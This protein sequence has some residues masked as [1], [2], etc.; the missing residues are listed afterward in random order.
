[1]ITVVGISGNST[2][3]ARICGSTASTIEPFAARRYRGGS[4]LAR[5]LFTVLRDI[6]NR[7]AMA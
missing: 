2:N 6:L 3:N 1:M 5:A 4:S 7:R